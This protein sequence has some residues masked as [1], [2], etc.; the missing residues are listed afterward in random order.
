MT[1][2]SEGPVLTGLCADAA[3]L[4]VAEVNLGGSILRFPIYNMIP[5]PGVPARL[6]FR[7]LTTDIHLD[8]A[9]REVDGTYKL[10]VEA[11]EIST[12]LPLLATKATIWGT[13]SDPSH[14]HRARQLFGDSRG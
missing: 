10:F 8:G 5:P 9:L 2:P 1:D 6:G 3:Q 11:N 4:G 12:A 13:P 7:A 14:R